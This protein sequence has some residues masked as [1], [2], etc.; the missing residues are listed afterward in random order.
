MKHKQKQG[1]ILPSLMAAMLVLSSNSHAATIIQ[2]VND[3]ANSDWNTH[4]LW[5]SPT[6]AVPTAGN[7]YV[8]SATGTG[9]GASA[10]TGLGS[11]VTMRVRDT[12]V[13]AFAGDSLAIVAGT[14][15]LLK[16]NATTSTG[17]I[18]LNGGTIR[19]APSSG[20]L[21]TLAGT[22][23]VAST[24][25]LGLAG[26]VSETFTVNS[27]LTG[28]SLLHLAAG[29]TANGT[30]ISGL[31]IAFG[32][33]LSAFT[34]TLD[35]GGGTT[36]TGAQAATLDFNQD[37]NLSAVS[38]IMGQSA[39]ADLLNLDQNLTFGS[40]TFNASSLGAGTYTAG[41]LNGL[42]GNGSQF[43]DGGGTLTIAAVPEPGTLAMLAGGLGM[44]GIFRR[45]KTT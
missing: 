8:T 38:L 22:L 31:V 20:T 3:G 12:G 33:D 5:G 16:N 30:Q 14:E 7:D 28:G 32:G 23:N 18:I 40:F 9:A 26:T 13:A 39:S 21:A 24:S 42:F 6:A 27:T 45:R 2:T 11:S 36:T 4:A 10:A 29:N 15:I 17:N 35:L 34:G 44:L 43:V 25:Y 1:A 19:Y 41:D 37:Y